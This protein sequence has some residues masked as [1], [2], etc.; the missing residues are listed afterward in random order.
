[1][2]K[3]HCHSLLS[4]SSWSS[5]GEDSPE[6]EAEGMYDCHT[7]NL[8]SHL[9]GKAPKKLF[10]GDLPCFVF[11]LIAMEVDDNNGSGAVE[12]T[13]LHREGMKTDISRLFFPQKKK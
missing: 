11:A 7:R 5:F 10:L 4:G 13:R 9:Y 3:I 6:E 1:M 8:C 12:A 2:A